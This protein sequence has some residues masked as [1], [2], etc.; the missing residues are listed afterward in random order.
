MAVSWPLVKHGTYDAGDVATAS[1]FEGDF[2]KVF[3]AVNQ[4]HN[5]FSSFQ[6]STQYN[7]RVQAET[8]FLSQG[9][10]TQPNLVHIFRVPD[11]MQALRV[12]R[13]SVANVSY[14]ENVDSYV[15]ADHSSGSLKFKLATASAVTAFNVNSYDDNW[16]ATNVATAD[17]TVAGGTAAS[18]YPF[19]GIA[20]G[21]GYPTILESD[22]TSN[23]VVLPDMYIA[24]YFIGGVTWSGSQNI[25]IQFDI[26][27][28]CDA[29]VPVP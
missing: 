27:I 26:N 20:S 29:M 17:F 10:A 15:Y 11:W 13:F 21:A 24:V 22:V 23:N 25:D 8:S 14:P 4:L 3:D 19:E 28:L 18:Q 5:R 6:I 1:N 16:S 9:A 2:N 7:E 12:R